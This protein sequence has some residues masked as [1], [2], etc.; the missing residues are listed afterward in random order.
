MIPRSIFVE[1]P[2]SAHQA[3]NKSARIQI[4]RHCIQRLNTSVWRVE[5][6]DYNTI[7]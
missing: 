6:K 4:L 7:H 3:I 5:P 2:T 1:K